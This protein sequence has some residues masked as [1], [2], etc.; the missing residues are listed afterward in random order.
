MGETCKDCSHADTSTSTTTLLADAS[1]DESNR[2]YPCLVAPASKK[3]KTSA[4]KGATP[5]AS[6][7]DV[8]SPPTGASKQAKSKTKKGDSTGEGG[9]LQFLAARVLMK[10]LYGARYARPDLLRA[11]CGLATKVTKWDAQADKEIHRLV[12]YIN[13]T[14]HLSLIHI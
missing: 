13:S 14:L 3:S 7:S 4:S 2:C 10:I 11:V 1:E 6:V 8:A 12:E 5:K 9:Q